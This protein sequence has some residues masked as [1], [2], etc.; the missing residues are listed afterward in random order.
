MRGPAILAWTMARDAGYPPGARLP[1][2]RHGKGPPSRAA[3]QP[4]GAPAQAANSTRTSAPFST[5]RAE[6]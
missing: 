6:A 5:G 1:R 2:R 4:C 3:L